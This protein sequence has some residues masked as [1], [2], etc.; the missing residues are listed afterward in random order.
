MFN[1]ALTGS[2]FSFTDQLKYFPVK[3]CLE[4]KQVEI[5]LPFRLFLKYIVHPFNTTR[6]VNKHLIYCK[7]F[8]PLLIYLETKRRKLS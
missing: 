8:S 5:I 3:S 1:L 7:L 6:H 4:P 2:K